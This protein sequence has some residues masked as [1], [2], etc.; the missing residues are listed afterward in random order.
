MQLFLPD[1]FLVVGFFVYIFNKI[2]LVSNYSSAVLAFIL[3]IKELLSATDIL[4]NWV[5]KKKRNAQNHKCN[6]PASSLLDLNVQH[7][8][9]PDL[10]LFVGIFNPFYSIGQ[11][12]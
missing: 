4:F 8:F 6:K 5:Y 12:L 1:L 7:P 11:L 9:E 10:C 3:E 2:S